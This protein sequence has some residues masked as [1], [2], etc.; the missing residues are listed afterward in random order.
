MSA[1][2]RL[3]YWRM[4]DLTS[5]EHR[6]EVQFYD[7]IADL[8]RNYGTLCLCSQ[9]SPLEAPKT[10]FAGLVKCAQTD[11][12]AVIDKRGSHLRVQKDSTVYAIAKAAQAH[13]AA[14]TWSSTDEGTTS[15]GKVVEVA[16]EYLLAGAFNLEIQMRSV[17]YSIEVWTLQEDS[18]PNFNA[19][20]G[21]YWGELIAE[22]KSGVY[23]SW[24]DPDTISLSLTLDAGKYLVRAQHGLGYDYLGSL[25]L[26]WAAAPAEDF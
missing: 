23:Y 16:S 15:T 2:E 3:A 18:T 12:F 24:D 13:L 26:Q 9:R 5:A 4:D 7:K 1:T 22:K 25:D 21:L 20:S 14:T 6:F 10:N 11:P 17:D 8:Q 19:E